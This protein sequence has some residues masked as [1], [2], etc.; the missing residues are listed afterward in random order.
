M[1]DVYIYYQQSTLIRESLAIN[2]NRPR[3][4]KYNDKSDTTT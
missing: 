1:A 2:T 4:D 3:L